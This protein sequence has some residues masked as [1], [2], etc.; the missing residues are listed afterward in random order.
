MVI[1]FV[2]LE[3]EILLCFLINSKRIGLKWISTRG[4]IASYIAN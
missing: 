1:A 4:L 2:I 3:L